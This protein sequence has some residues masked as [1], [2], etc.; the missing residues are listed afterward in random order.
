[1]NHVLFAQASGH[2]DSQ[3]RGSIPQVQLLLDFLHLAAYKNQKPVQKVR[4]K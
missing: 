2:H 1:M 4:S 3:T